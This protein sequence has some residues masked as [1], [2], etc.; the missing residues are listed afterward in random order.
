MM[1]NNIILVDVD[2][3]L[4]DWEFMFEQWM[5]RHGHV[6]A[7]DNYDVSV[8]YELDKD[9]SQR[10]VRMFN[11]SARMRYLPPLRDAVTYVKKLHEQHG[12]VFHA[13]TS[14]SNDHYAQQLRTQN[15]QDLFGDSTF[16]K[17]IYLDTGE[18]KS[19]VLMNYMKSGCIWVEDKPQNASQGSLLG[20]DAL[21]MQH[22]F[23]MNFNC[24]EHNVQMVR[25][26]REIY[27]YVIENGYSD[28]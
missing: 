3:V 7:H 2:G 16:Q 1:K 19:N 14:M 24:Q 11:E 17:I 15:L 28:V 18:D 22:N 27:Y 20:L 4:V 5:S 23:N 9:Y 8:S 25:N 10:M 21:L 26:W 6:K 13:I 12:F